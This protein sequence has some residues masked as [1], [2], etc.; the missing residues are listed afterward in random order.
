MNTLQQD[1]IT[2][3]IVIK[4]PIERVFSALTEAEHLAT[5]FAEGIDGGLEPGEQ[6][7]WDFGNYGRAKVLMVAADRP[8]YVAYRWVPGGTVTFVGDLTTRPTTLC[9]FRLEEVD[10]GTKV[11]LVESGFLSLPQEEIEASFKDNDSGWEE[12]LPKLGA[13]AESL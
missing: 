4:A 5:W 6:S 9:E 13:Y 1:T 2:R 11:S 12:M 7:L 3:D 10:G 8:N